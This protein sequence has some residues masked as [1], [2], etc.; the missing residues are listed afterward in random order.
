MPADF[1]NVIKE[2][3][4]SKP[5][6]VRYLDT[7]FRD[8]STLNYLKSI[9]PGTSKGDTCVFN[10]RALKY[11]SGSGA[12]YKIKFDDQWNFLPHRITRQQT[13]ESITTP[14]LYNHRLLI[15]KRKYEDLQHLTRM[16][17]QIFMKICLMNDIYYF[18]SHNYFF[19]TLILNFANEKLLFNLF[20]TSKY[21]L[22]KY[23]FNVLLHL[24]T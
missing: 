1:I 23:N 24:H 7:L 3:I 8:F 5:Y 2:A 13:G 15:N 11:T 19:L 6:Q 14:E 22:N 16:I 9:R 12:Q 21:F 18:L 17:P 4:A 10:L 20:T